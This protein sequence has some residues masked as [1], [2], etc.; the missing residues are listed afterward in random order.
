[1]DEEPK[2]KKKDIAIQKRAAVLLAPYYKVTGKDY[3]YVNPKTKEEWAKL[4]AENCRHYEG[5][6][7]K[8]MRELVKMEAADP[9]DAQNCSLMIKEFMEFAADY[10]Q[11]H[12]IPVTFHGY[13]I[14]PVGDEPRW[15]LRVAV[16]GVAA[17]G[18]LDTNAILGAVECLRTAD[19]F[20]IDTSGFRA[21][22]D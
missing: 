17:E 22:W 20:D 19:E 21:W 4:E 10:E 1:M 14:Y 13:Q 7:L 15:D 6:P 3:S 9:E 16:E 11:A 8:V 12:G 5:V 18:K 2:A